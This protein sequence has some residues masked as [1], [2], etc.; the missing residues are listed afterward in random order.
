MLSPLVPTVSPECPWQE[1]PGRSPLAGAPWQEPPGRSPLAG[2][3]WQEPPGR[4]P[5]AE[6]IRPSSPR[7]HW[8]VVGPDGRESVYRPLSRSTALGV[9]AYSLLAALLGSPVILTPRFLAGFFRMAVRFAA[10]AD[11]GFGSRRIREERG[12]DE[13][14]CVCGGV[15][16]DGR[17]A[18][19][20]NGAGVDRARNRSVIGRP[21]PRGGRTWVA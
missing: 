10:K 1:P 4:S 17:R 2:A 18:D 12:S 11:Q 8:S 5:L 21:D 19:G 15:H 3:P 14:A 7:G 16:G 9:E 6:P 13:K 20:G